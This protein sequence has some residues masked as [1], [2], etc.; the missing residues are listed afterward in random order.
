MVRRIYLD[1]VAIR[2]RIKLSGAFIAFGSGP[3]TEAGWLSAEAYWRVYQDW[4]AWTEEGIID[5]AIPMIYQ[6]DHLTSGRAAFNRWNDWVRTH[7]YSRSAMMGIGS[8]LNSIEGSLTQ[9]R[10]ALQPSALG[11]RNLGV[12]VFSMRRAM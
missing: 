4:R 1:A 11:N 2:P 10:R 8:F 6:R 3:T 5:V 7:Q 12:N 9:V